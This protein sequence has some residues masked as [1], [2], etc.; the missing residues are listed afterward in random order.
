MPGIYGAI[1]S[2]VLGGSPTGN[3]ATANEAAIQAQKQ[4]LEAKH[5]PMKFVTTN[6]AYARREEWGFF[7]MCFVRH[8]EYCVTLMRKQVYSSIF[9]IDPLRML[10]GGRDR[11]PCL[12]DE[13][14]GLLVHAYNG[15]G[16]IVGFFVSLQRLLHIG[17]ELAVSVGIWTSY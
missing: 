10:F 14:H 8:K 6:N 7:P 17:D 2:A 1:L 9:V 3:P 15:A 4:C 11:Y 16:G 13:L 5:G 12:A